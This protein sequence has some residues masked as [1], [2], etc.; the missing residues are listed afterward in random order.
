M[1]LKHL[2]STSAFI[3]AGIQTANS[4]N[5]KEEK[6]FHCTA[7]PVGYYSKGGAV[8]SCTKCPAGTYSSTVGSSSCTPCPKGQYQD[9][10]GQTSCKACPAGTYSSAGSSSC[11]PCP[12]GQYQNLAGQSSCK[13]CTGSTFS[14]S[15]GATSCT[16]CSNSSESCTYYVDESYTDTCSDTCTREVEGSPTCVEYGTSTSCSH[17]GY[18]GSNGTCEICV[19]YERPTKTESYSCSKS[20]TK[21]R[22]VTKSGRRTLYYKVNSSHTACQYS[23]T[24]QCD[25]NTK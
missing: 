2:I 19:R 7:C 10:S 22:T 15:T 6:Y 23:S 18:G 11:T 3:L 1:K 5:P 24:G 8:T 20:C 9:L 25:N 17:S 12:K 21:T 14:S 16:T 13:A 4:A